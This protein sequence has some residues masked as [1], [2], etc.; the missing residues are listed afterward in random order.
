MIDLHCWLLIDVG[1]RE[2]SIKTICQYTRRLLQ[3][4]D[5]HCITVAQFLTSQ[6]TLQ[7]VL[8]SVELDEFEVSSFLFAVNKWKEIEN[9]VEESE[10][11]REINVSSAIQQYNSSINSFLGDTFHP[12]I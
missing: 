7:Q 1:L 4:T 12:F 2:D 3:L 11:W 9:G 10:I 6:R 8:E 5:N